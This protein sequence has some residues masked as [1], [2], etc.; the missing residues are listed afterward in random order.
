MKSQNTQDPGIV[1]MTVRDLL[2]TV[3]AGFNWEMVTQRYDPDPVGTAL[4]IYFTD[5]SGKEKIEEIHL[6]IAEGPELVV[7]DG[8]D[9][10]WDFIGSIVTKQDIGIR[11]LDPDDDMDPDR[12][13]FHHGR[14]EIHPAE[15]EGRER[16][17]LVCSQ[18]LDVMLESIIWKRQQEGG[19]D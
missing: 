9:P 13:R 7:L 3:N 12:A 11:I 17:W 14:V 1:E 10:R 19:G 4:T 15:G 2:P 18:V 8:L 6:G 16:V 5:E